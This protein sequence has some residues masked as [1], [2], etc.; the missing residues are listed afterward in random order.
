MKIVKFTPH[1]SELIKAGTKV[2][3]FRLFDDKDLRVGDKFIMA[4]RDGNLVTEF[5]TAVITEVI[6]RTIDTL[7]SEDYA[8]HEPVEN[9]IEYY[10]QFYGD[11]VTGESEVKVIKFDVLSQ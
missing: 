10:K 2:T 1:L 6:I 9:P 3:T 8:G 7:K 5:G 11:K 4:T